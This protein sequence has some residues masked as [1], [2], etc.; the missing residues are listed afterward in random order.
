MCKKSG[1]VKD[2]CHWLLQCPG[3]DHIRQPL[4]TVPGLR[5]L[6]EGTTAQKRTAVILSM[7]FFNDSVLHCISSMWFRTVTHRTFI[8][9]LHPMGSNQELFG[10]SFQISPF[11][12]GI[13]S[14]MD[15]GETGG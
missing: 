7:A 11:G 10:G 4:I 2:V 9:Y 15:A 8:Y 3:C 1:E 6:P 14:G 13:G 12:L 5:D